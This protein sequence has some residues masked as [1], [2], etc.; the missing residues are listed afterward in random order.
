MPDVLIYN[1][2]GRAYY[3]PQPLRT[4]ANIRGSH[5]D[6]TLLT[7]LKQKLQTTLYY[8]ALDPSLLPVH[9]QKRPAQLVL[10]QLPLLDRVC[11][12]VPRG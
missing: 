7:R 4:M 10:E 11:P 2:T 9:L 1:D 8:S 3:Y 12:P 6:T 5:A